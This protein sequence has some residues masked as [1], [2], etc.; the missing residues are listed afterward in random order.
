MPWIGTI[1]NHSAAG[2]DDIAQINEKDPILVTSSLVCNVQAA[3]GKG[4]MKLV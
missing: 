4:W 3:L 1:V 2:C